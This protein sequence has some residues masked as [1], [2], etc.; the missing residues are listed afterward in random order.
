MLTDT[1]KTAV[2]SKA[3]PFQRVGGYMADI[4]YDPEKLVFHKYRVGT[5]LTI[6]GET[7]KIVV[8]SDSEVVV[9]ATSN[10]KMTTIKYTGKP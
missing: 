2:I 3:K 4:K 10:A 8:I 7:Y 5:P 6:G 1:G 9:S